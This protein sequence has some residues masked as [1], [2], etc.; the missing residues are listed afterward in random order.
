MISGQSSS[1]ARVWSETDEGR[2]PCGW[3][4]PFHARETV[5]AARQAAD[6]FFALESAAKN[7]TFGAC[8]GQ[9]GFSRVAS[10]KE[11]VVLSGRE[12]PDILSP[13]VPFWRACH[14]QAIGLLA[15]MALSLQIAPER[16][17]EIAPTDPQAG[18][19]GGS[20][21]RLIRHPGARR[22]LATG[23]HQ[24]S[25]LLSLVLKTSEP[26]LRTTPAPWRDLVH[27]E[28]EA[29]ADSVMVLAGQAMAELSNGRVGACLHSVAATRRPRLSLVY[30]L[31]P[32]PDAWIDSDLL[33]SPVTGSFARPF[34]LSGED[35]FRQ[36]CHRGQSIHTAHPWEL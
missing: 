27:L 36:R 25:G 26:A 1:H 32:R 17:L 30:H 19:G 10:G 3:T 15:D 7:L 16:L 23:W 24:D 12:V 31:R 2:A 34:R 14:R 8:A 20:V 28:E 6:R 11:M 22:G 21:L 4:T 18:P 5:G 29:P 35:F 33:T 13:V 9:D